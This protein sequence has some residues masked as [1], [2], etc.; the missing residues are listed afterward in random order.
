MKEKEKEQ[1]LEAP[2]EKIYQIPEEEEKQLKN[3]QT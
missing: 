1:I 3:F 2:Y